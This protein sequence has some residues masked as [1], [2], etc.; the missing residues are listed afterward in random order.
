[1]NLD[2]VRRDDWIIGGL[3][4]L[5]LIDLLFLPWFDVSLGS[6]LGISVSVTSTATGDPDGWLGILAAIATLV[7]LADLGVER[8]SPTTQMPAISRSRAV[9]RFVFAGLAAFFLVLKFL[10]HVNHFSDLGFG[11]WAAV[12]LTAGL[13]YFT[14]QARQAE[15]IAPP[16]PSEPA[17]PAGPAGPPAESSAGPAGPPAGPPGPPAGPPAG[18]SGPPSA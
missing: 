4:L 11:F 12:V 8:L 2:N 7:V 9:T 5:L 13:V 17:A 14:A 3:A 10:F 16:R 18:S 6:A 1:V 15:R